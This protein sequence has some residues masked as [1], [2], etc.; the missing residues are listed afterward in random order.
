MGM[1]KRSILKDENGSAIVIALLAL[2][3][4]TVIGVSSTG[5]TT[6]E[7]LVVRN[8][9]VYQDNFYLAEAAATEAAERLEVSTDDDLEN[10]TPV[11]L[12]NTSDMDDTTNWNTANSQ[13]SAYTGAQF[14]VVE[15]G[16][17]YGS[18]MDMTESDNMYEYTA[19]GYSTSN[20]GEVLIG[21]GYKKR[22]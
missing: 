4:L 14:A 22:H 3:A 19:W 17:A 12:T 15:E 1:R 13:T 18:S 5:V 10:R 8:T 9:N 21:M 6:T 11:W 2:A 7:L 16:I 20:N